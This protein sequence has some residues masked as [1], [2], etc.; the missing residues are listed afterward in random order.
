MVFKWRFDGGPM[1]SACYMMN[2]R[3]L[4]CECN[5]YREVLGIRILRPRSPCVPAQALP[6]PISKVRRRCMCQIS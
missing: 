3:R 2:V 5:T 1:V 6:R 4:R